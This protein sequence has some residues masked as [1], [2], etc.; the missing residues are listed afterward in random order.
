[1]CAFLFALLMGNEFNFSIKKLS[2]KGLY[3]PVTVWGTL[4]ILN[5]I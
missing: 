1:M 3:E 4:Y 5:L 2:F